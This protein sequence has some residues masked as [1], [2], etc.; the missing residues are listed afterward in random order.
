MIT[1]AEEIKSTLYGLIDMIDYYERVASLPDCNDCGGNNM[2]MYAPKPGQQ[3]RIN[4][5]L[6]SGTQK[7]DMSNE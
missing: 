7:E 1:N 4:C 5:P 2:C 3:V 6:W